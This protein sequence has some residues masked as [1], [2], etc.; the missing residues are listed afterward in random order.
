MEERAE[1]DNPARQYSPARCSGD[2]R[3]ST[4]ESNAYDRGYFMATVF[5]IDLPT[6]RFQP[7]SYNA[8]FVACS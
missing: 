4:E 6:R 7:F 2:Q 3:S 8:R 5:L 1:G